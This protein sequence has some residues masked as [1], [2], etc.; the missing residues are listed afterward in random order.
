MVVP[1]PLRMVRDDWVWVLGSDRR[2]W[3]CRGRREWFATIGFE[4]GSDR[5]EWCCRTVTNGFAGPSQIVIGDGLGVIGDGE[6]RRRLG[7]GVRL[8]GDCV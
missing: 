3:C 5:R 2:E 1:E 7:L 4:F 6:A 8:D